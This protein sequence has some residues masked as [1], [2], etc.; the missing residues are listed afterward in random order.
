MCHRLVL[1]E[2]ILRWVL[3]SGGQLLWINTGGEEVEEKGSG[4]GNTH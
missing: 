4:A 1:W 2:Q 3:P